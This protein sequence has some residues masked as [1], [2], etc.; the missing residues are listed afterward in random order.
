MRFGSR[1]SAELRGKHSKRSVRPRVGDSVRIVRGEF[2][3]I[4]GKITK[5]DSFTGVV[6]VEGVTHEK[7]KGGTAPVPIRSSNV[8]VT[9]LVLEDKL[10][11]RRLEV[12]A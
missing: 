12:P 4:E 1:L 5:V 10:R 3:G 6:N 9:A 7:L 11:K 8:V 2:K